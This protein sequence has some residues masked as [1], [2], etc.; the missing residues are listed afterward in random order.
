MQGGGRFGLRSVRFFFFFFLSFSNA[1]NPLFLVLLFF[2]SSLNVGDGFSPVAGGG[3]FFGLGET[4]SK[5]L[6]QGKGR[7][8]KPPR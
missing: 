5:E 7:R 6:L 2:F 4:D 3:Y 1:I 8:L